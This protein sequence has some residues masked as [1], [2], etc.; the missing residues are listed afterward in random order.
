MLTV[1]GWRKMN[2]LL[3]CE[4]RE[5][6]Q[7][8]E[9]DNQDGNVERLVIGQRLFYRWIVGRLTEIN[10]WMTQLRC[11]RSP[12]YL[13][14]IEYWG[15]ADP[16]RQDSVFLGLSSIHDLP[17]ATCASGSRSR[18][19][20]CL[21]SC[22]QTSCSYLSPSKCATPDTRRSYTSSIQCHSGTKWTDTLIQ[23]QG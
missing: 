23:T 2:V 13:L 12:A 11:P 1:G 19:T 17:P 9:E 6:F 16:W 10:R 14:R 8:A 18:S 5:R 3:T 21:A 15:G 22:A 7:R 4:T 20:I